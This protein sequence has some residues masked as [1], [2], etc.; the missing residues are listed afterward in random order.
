MAL[1]G[2]PQAVRQGAESLLRH[3]AEFADQSAHLSNIGRGVAW[4]WEGEAARAFVKALTRVSQRL[5]RTSAAMAAAGRALAIYATEL[6]AAQR[7][8]DS[9]HAALLRAH[10][11]LQAARAMPFTYHA[12]TREM[13]GAERAMQAAQ[14]RLS[15]AVTAEG[16]ANRRA[17]VQIRQALQTLHG[18][19]AP[20]LA[21][22]PQMLAV[23]PAPRG[24]EASIET[25]ETKKPGGQ[26]RHT[27]ALDFD[28]QAATVLGFAFA[29]EGQKIGQQAHGPALVRGSQSSVATRLR[30][31]SL[32]APTGPGAKLGVGATAVG[33][34]FTAY[35]N[36]VVEDQSM[37]AGAVETGLDTSISLASA[38][39]AGA[40]AGTVLGGPFGTVPGAAIAVVTVVGGW[41]LANAIGYWTAPASEAVGAYVDDR[42]DNEPTEGR[43]RRNR[44]D[45]DDAGIDQSSAP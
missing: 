2:N 4:E 8:F 12:R 5:D 16:E 37:L 27:P 3:S 14:S 17:A 45:N 35:E 7:S 11:N 44:N 30:Q 19:S 18:R 34:G 43:T 33:V 38:A 24:S 28:Y 29:S 21:Q 23:R 39:A 15:S 22:S 20:V 42:V 40:V 32:L 25:E 41:A 26:P 10:R 36:F 6:A 13:A 1:S 9:A 31:P